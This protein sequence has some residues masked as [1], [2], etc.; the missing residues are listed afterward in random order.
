MADVFDSEKRSE[1]M[2]RITGKDTEPEIKIRKTL[3]G[4]GYRYSLHKKNLPGKPDIYLRKYNGLIEINGCYWHGHD[5][6]FFKW[7]ENNKEFWK[8]KIRR[9]KERDR[10][11]FKK[12]QNM[13]YRLLVIWE[14]A[15]TGKTSLDFEMLID[16]IIR[17]LHSDIKF[18]EIEGDN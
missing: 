1:V 11:N 13:G 6:H 5:C 3:H 8:N 15:I 9:T 2:S 17:W 16:Y 7:P 10:N 12:L 4:L 18:K 14:C